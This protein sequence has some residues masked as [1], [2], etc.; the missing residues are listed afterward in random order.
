MSVI[1][2]LQSWAEISMVSMI[3]S[4]AYIAAESNGKNTSF[5]IL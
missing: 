4:V 2:E 3:E 1:D 5:Q